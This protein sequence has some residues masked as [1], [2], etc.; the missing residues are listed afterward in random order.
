W[1]GVFP[2]W[3]RRAVPAS[4]LLRTDSFGNR[5]R[6]S[7]TCRDGKRIAIKKGPDPIFPFFPQEKGKYR[8]W[9][10]FS[11][12]EGFGAG[13]TFLWAA[14]PDK[15]TYFRTRLPGMVRRLTGWCVRMKPIPTSA[16]T[17]RRKCSLR[18]GAAWSVMK[19]DVRCARGFT[20]S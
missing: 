1:H 3:R 10:L 5:G 7:S 20:E 18:F 12:N 14:V 9:S 15:T 19:P 2:K 16:E 13:T 4:S 8:V 17:F 6:S 11:G